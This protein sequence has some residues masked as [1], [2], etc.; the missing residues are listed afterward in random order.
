MSTDKSFVSLENAACPV[1]C[2]KHQTGNLLLDRRLRPSMERD[3]CTHWAFCPECAKLRDDGYIA[4]V[5][6]DEKKSN[7]MTVA[8][9]WRIGTIMHVKAEAWRKIFNCPAPKQGLAFVE[10]KVI[11]MLQS[12]MNPANQ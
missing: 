8:E 3:T 11:E 10:P 12:K 5:A 9:A 7:A 4:L 6:A 1:C 2:R